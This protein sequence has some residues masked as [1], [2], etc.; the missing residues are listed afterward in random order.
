M[1]CS[2]YNANKTLT[3]SLLYARPSFLTTPGFLVDADHAFVGK[4]GYLEPG[5][6]HRIGFWTCTQ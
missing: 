4:L 3:D 6:C 1:Y 2:V 5:H